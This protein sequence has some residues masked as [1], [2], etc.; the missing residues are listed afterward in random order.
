MQEPE[1][2]LLFTRPL[3]A[4]GIPYMVTGSIAGILYGEPRVTHDV[5]LVVQLGRGRA[6]AL[7]AAFPASA[8]YVPPEEVIAVE[9]ARD[10]HGHFNVIHHSSGFKADFYLVG[11]DPLH[12]WGLERRIRLPLGPAE[13]WVAPV[14]YVVIRKLQFFREGG[15]QKHVRDIRG[16]IALNPALRED[17]ELLRWVERL[18]LAEEWNAVSVG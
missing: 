1:L 7:V 5:D 10:R 8:F 18:G 12:P 16:M 9:V 14:Q 6:A 15:S 4:L 2:V 3:D 13:V 11:Q 17:A